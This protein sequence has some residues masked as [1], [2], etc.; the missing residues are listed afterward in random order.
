MSTEINRQ[1]KWLKV[2][3][4]FAAY[5][6]AAWTFLQFVDWVLNRYDISPYWVDVLLWL[7][8]GIIPSLLIYLYH[9]ERLNKLIF[10]RREK[11][12]IPLNI[13][14]LVM[15]LYFVFGNSDLGATTKEISFENTEGQL[16]TKRFTKEEF[17]VGVP[18]YGF[19]QISED[20][21]ISWMRYGIGKLLL[22][23]L[24]QN[25]NLS[26]E[27]MFLTNTT[28]KIREASL[29]N[30]FYI[31][32]NYQKI[33]DNYEITTFI[34][35]ATNGK[36][37]KQQLFKGPDVL[38]L[39]DDIS[40]YITSESG[41]VESNNL[42]YIDLPINEFISNSLPAIEAYTNGDYK[43]AYDIDS[44]FALA[45]L[46]EAER[47]RNYNKGK[48]ETQDIIDKAA[49]LKNKLPLQKQLE[50]SIQRNLAYDNY[51]EAEKLVKLQLEVDP[52]NDFYNRVLFSIYGET[53]NTTAFLNTAD[54]LFKNDPNAE[55]GINLSKAA[56]VNGEDQR[57][58][59]EIGTYEMINPRVRALKLEPL[60]FQGD[61]NSAEKLFN[62][63]KL[64]YPEYKNRSRAYDSIF[65]FLKSDDYQSKN[66]EQF[67][68]LYRSAINEQVKEYWIENDRLIQYVKN[69]DMSAFLPAGKHAFGGGFILETTFY[70]ELIKDTNGKPIGLNTFQ[71]NWS[72]TINRLY[73]KI[74]TSISKANEAYENNNLE[75]AEKLFEIAIENN[76]KHVYLKN[77]L[78]HLVYLRTK[79]SDSLQRQFK[80]HSGTYGPRNF[81]VEDGK[82]YYKRKGN[83]ADLA[84][85]E[86]LPISEN[87]YIDLTR[88]ST[89]MEFEPL[90]NDTFASFAHSFNTNTW[91]W[92]VLKDE[93]NFF[94]KE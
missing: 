53:K 75:A 68:G 17:R 69:Q 19:N 66:L 43:K 77:I 6:V 2:L 93:T 45:Y 54:A 50:I 38:K 55:T 26:P 60:L 91:E 59:D 80:R 34:R 52:N 64:T 63:L 11:I 7:F 81:W 79:N 36:V 73:W 4:F 67:V 62:E 23:D 61:V 84:R 74:D 15:T 51:E 42:R 71:F 20:S 22:E 78:E 10:R 5:L 28:T 92:E 41:F 65:T 72:N 27:F 16:E 90:D 32:G 18:I 88:L 31:D 76:P 33:G 44:K 56:L 30:E 35:K 70:T 83:T 21:T 29:F 58:L 39:L 57:I 9:Q 40:A 82:F 1:K 37:I 94:T 46:K 25:K 8:I 12:I 85:V 14:L 48:L 49:A 47:N 13:I 87:K 89:I 24:L 3:K 86:L